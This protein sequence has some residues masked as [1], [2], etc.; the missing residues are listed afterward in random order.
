M[1]AVGLVLLAGVIDVR[2]LRLLYLELLLYRRLND[3]MLGLA[4]DKGVSGALKVLVDL[5][6]ELEMK[7][8]LFLGF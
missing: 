2:L 4:C 1:D 6:G 3:L 8:G 7:S 5:L